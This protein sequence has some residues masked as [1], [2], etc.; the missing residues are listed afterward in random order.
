MGEVLLELEG[1]TKKYN[2]GDVDVPVLHGI[3]LNIETGESREIPLHGIHRQLLNHTV[4]EFAWRPDGKIIAIR[5]GFLG[6]VLKLDNDAPW[7]RM[8]AADKVFFVPVDWTPSPECLKVGEGDEYPSPDAND[9]KAEISPPGGDESK[10]WW[11]RELPEHVLTMK[12][13]DANEAKQRSHADA[14]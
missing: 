7:P 2:L 13:I 8:F 9:P 11:V 4:H 12:W 6:G 1:V 14:R 3:T 5:C 10:P